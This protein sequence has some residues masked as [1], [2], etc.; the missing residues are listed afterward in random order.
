MKMKG[1]CVMHCMAVAALMTMAS[2]HS[3]EAN[4][5]AAYDRAVDRTKDGVGLEAY[6]KVLEERNRNNYMVNGDSL[7]MI[8]DHCNIVDGKSEEVMTYSVVVAEFK[9][10]F[11]ATSLRNRLRDEEK[12]PAYVVYT[13][14]EK[15]YCVVASG[16]DEAAG[17]AAFVKSIGKRMKIKPL[18][19][20][21]WVLQRI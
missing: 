18:V 9:Q 20:K 11:N 17:A 4:Y 10:K 15:K 1:K 14:S 6:T 2:C 3:N 7:R 13:A 21:V 8:L 5:K 19:P 12:L 16:F